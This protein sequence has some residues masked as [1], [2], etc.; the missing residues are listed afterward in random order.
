[1][2]ILLAEDNHDHRE[3]LEVVLTRT[4]A[5]WEVRSVQTGD[6]FLRRL[7]SSDFDVGLLDYH[8]PDRDAAEVLACVDQL[9]ECPPIIV[10]SSDDDSETII[11]TL[12]SGGRDFL[13]KS[14][15]FN[16][17]RLACRI[18]QVHRRRQ[19]EHGVIQ[20]QKE[21]CISVLAGG[22]AHDFNNMLV[23]I[24]GKASMLEELLPQQ[25]TSRELCQGI[26]RTAHRMSD[27][28]KQ[29]LAYARGGKYHPKALS[30]DD[31]IQDTLAI[32]AG[33]VKPGITLRTALDAGATYVEA[34]HSQ[35]VQALLNLCLNA[36][37]ALDGH[38][39]LRIA[40]RATHKDAPWNCALG[41]RHGAGDF[42]QI[43]IADNGP[44]I[45][46]AVQARMF[47]PFYSTKGAGRGLGLAAVQGIVRNH[48]GG[49]LV[50]SSAATGT[51]FQIL[52][53]AH[54]EAAPP[55]P[56]R[57]VPAA[58]PHMER[59]TVLIVEDE[60]EVREVAG[61]ILRRAGHRVLSVGTGAEARELLRASARTIDVVLLDM[62]LPDCGGEEVLA[63][64][65]RQRADLPVLICSG[66]DRAAVMRD[67]V[68]D[69]PRVAFLPK[70]FIAGQL[71]ESVTA[72]VLGARSKATAE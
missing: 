49:L 67:V 31:A 16:A 33:S 51:T 29:L 35:L 22:I 64:A 52:L 38:G 27:L 72:L 12:R 56:A 61:D 70:P 1:M 18:Q 59:S 26:Q 41:L 37:E 36:C 4:H 6:E 42:V 63:F 19:M 9:P 34:D 11:S 53:P 54:R 15:A 50:R 60:P 23:G 24:L 57:S 58:K 2:R 5:D 55:A 45:A 65:R 3:L 14:E 66:Y 46:S 21:E 47:E 13:P 71:L 7:M 30:V 28:A 43:E 25:G 10:I 44:G 68:T 39:E 62:R 48:H 32:L 8:L 17:Q 40:T 20:R 69:D